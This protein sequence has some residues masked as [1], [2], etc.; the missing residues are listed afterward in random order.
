MA[1]TRIQ[2]IYLRSRGATMMLAFAMCGCAASDGG[3]SPL[4]QFG[5]SYARSAVFVSEHIP[6]KICFPKEY[7][8]NAR[9]VRERERASE[10]RLDTVRSTEGPLVPGGR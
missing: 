2:P 7:A 6:Y 4:A 3:R 5:D 10:N 8:E 1:N 9:V